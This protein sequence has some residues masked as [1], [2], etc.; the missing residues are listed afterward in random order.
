MVPTKQEI[1]QKLQ[2]MAGVI[3]DT[4][5]RAS[6]FINAATS[7]PQNLENQVR[8]LGRQS[9]VFIKKQKLELEIRFL[10]LRL[11]ETEKRI[12]EELG[13]NREENTRP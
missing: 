3:D 7:D 1:E 10:K 8:Q 11:Q 12:E 4:V 5:S 2:K 6:S 9:A 13:K